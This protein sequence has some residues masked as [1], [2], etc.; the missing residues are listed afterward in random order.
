MGIENAQR[1]RSILGLSPSIVQEP[2]LATS[3]VKTW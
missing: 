1:P 2:I 3:P